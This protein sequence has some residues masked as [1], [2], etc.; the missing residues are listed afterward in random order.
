MIRGDTKDFNF[1]IKQDGQYIDGSQYDEVEVQFNPE[2]IGVKKLK[3]RNEVIWDNDHF[4][5]PL[6]QED[7]FKLNS[8]AVEFQVRIYKNNQCKGTLKQQIIVGDVLSNK[9]LG[10]E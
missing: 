8:G 10:E 1:K 4:S 6:S 9:I 2:E 3:S 5:C 7:T